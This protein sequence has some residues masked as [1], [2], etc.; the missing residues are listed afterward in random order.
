MATSIINGM[1]T[2]SFTRNVGT[3]H[4]V[5][6]FQSGNVVTI[7]G[8]VQGITITANTETILGSFSGVSAP[9]NI[10]RTVGAVSSQA[11]NPPA[12]MIYLAVSTAGVI[13]FNAPSASA[14]SGKVIYFTVTYIV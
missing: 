1:K 12:Q 9:R 6:V 14:G 10:V 3:S 8:H 7:T 11:Y 2:G 13:L 5:S 4:T